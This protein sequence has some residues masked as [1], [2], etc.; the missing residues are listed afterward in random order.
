MPLVVLQDH[1]VGHILVE[2]NGS[3]LQLFAKTVDEDF[4]R[5]FR[6]VLRGT[7]DCIEVD[8]RKCTFASILLSCVRPEPVENS[9]LGSYVLNLDPVLLFPG[10]RSL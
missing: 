2:L 9:V 6:F 7:S 4:C 10:L 3:P 1:T 8:C 5:H